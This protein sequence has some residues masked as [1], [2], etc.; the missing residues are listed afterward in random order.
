MF[1]RRAGLVRGVSIGLR[2]LLVSGAMTAA[3]AA[4]DCDAAMAESQFRAGKDLLAQ[5]DYARACPLLADSFRLDPATGSLLALALCHERQGKI[6]TAFLEYEE[7]A[8]RSKR[9]GRRDREKA[10]REKARCLGAQLSLL[11]IKVAPEAQEIDGLEVKRNGVAMDTSTW[12]KPMPVDGGEQIIE[13]SAPGMA[14]WRTTT[15]IGAKQDTKWVLVPPLQEEPEERPV[16]P[17]PTHAAEKGTAK[18]ALPAPK[19][20]LAPSPKVVLTNEDARADVRGSPRRYVLQ[21]A[22]VAT[23]LAGVVGVGIGTGFLLRAIAKNNDSKAGC[24]GNVCS[25]QGTQDRWEAED[26]GNVATISFVAGGVLLAGGAVMYILG[27]PRRSLSACAGSTCVEAAPLAIER[28]FG[29]VV[30]G[31]FW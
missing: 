12:G 10:A 15:S 28:G 5:K 29:G 21:G 18:P 3:D 11:T 23:A 22:G 13:A 16:A 14:P 27:R 8:A 4:D 9:E 24:N 1:R 26:A 20:T 19:P 7:V 30:Q 31:S 25:L 2:V 17:I 6:A